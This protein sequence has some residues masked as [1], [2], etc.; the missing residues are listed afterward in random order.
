[1]AVMCVLSALVAGGCPG[2]DAADDPD[3]SGGSAGDGPSLLPALDAWRTLP[4]PPVLAE[5]VPGQCERHSDCDDGLFCTG[6]ELCDDNDASADA[7]GCVRPRRAPCTGGEICDEVAGAC[8]PAP[9]TGP[10]SRRCSDDDDCDDGV[11][12]NGPERCLPRMPGADSCGCF[13]AA[14]PPCARDQMCM[15]DEA[16]CVTTCDYGLDNDGDAHQNPQCGGDD[17]DDDDPLRYPG[18][19]EVCD[20]DDRDEDCDPS[21]F[22]F[23]DDDG[24]GYGDDGCCNGDDNGDDPVCGDDCDDGVA[25]VHPSEAE[26]CDLRDNDCDGAVDEEV[27]PQLYTDADG[28]G[29]G[30]G[31]PAAA[32]AGMPNTSTRAGDC[33]DGNPAL[34]PGA[35][36][37]G[38]AAGAIEVCALDGT[39]TAETCGVNAQAL[40]IPCIDQPNGTGHCLQEP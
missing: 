24:D 40:A 37:C 7:C 9:S 1:M 27:A 34:H 31:A 21:S 33:D 8:W 6:R 17:C 10:C 13:H 28:D 23:R 20:A 38:A 25:S 30:T 39:W 14:A 5:C 19:I 2:D 36:R 11:F 18:A 15:E 4:R 22:G 35:M 16:T 32:C 29:Y 12:C 26:S 3:E